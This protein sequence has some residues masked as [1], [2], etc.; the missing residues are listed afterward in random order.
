MA[1]MLGKAI[2]ITIFLARSADPYFP[3]CAPKHHER[4]TKT[5][6]RLKW[7]GE[8]TITDWCRCSFITHYN[9]VAQS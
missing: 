3:I 6:Y 1:N 2:L 4:L 9:S 7:H 8:M 5:I